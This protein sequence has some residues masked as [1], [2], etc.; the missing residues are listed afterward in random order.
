VSEFV[1][2]K[3]QAAILKMLS[4]DGFVAT[5]DMVSKFDVTPQTIRRDL[6]ELNKFGLI[7]RFHGGAG[8]AKNMGNRPYKDRLHTRVE[9]KQTIAQLVSGLIPDGASLFLSSG[10]TIEAI[11]RELS[12]HKS[13]KVVTNNVNI[14]R[15]MSQNESFEV[16][17]AGG[18]VRNVDGG[19]IGLS[20]LEFLEQ[21]HMD[22]GI[23]GTNS[24]DE[25]G[26]L[27]DFDQLEVRISRATIKNSHKVILVADSEK[28]GRRAMNR[29]GHISE[30]N[31]LVT[32]KP[33]KAP[34]DQ[35]FAESNVKVIQPG[36]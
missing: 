21:F 10:T 13:L 20:S 23:V 18:Q 17:I 9:A 25:A 36:D 22:F 24:V 29:M 5:D 33:L 12:S 4:E 34:F 1:P 11:A 19:I 28:F 27:W 32:D 8:Q 30:C 7:T 15:I 26:A 14:A 16:M 2:N 3:R 35:L 6:N 31:F